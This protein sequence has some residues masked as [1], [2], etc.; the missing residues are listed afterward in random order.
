ME[1]KQ[2]R[3]LIFPQISKKHGKQKNDSRY[4]W[5]YAADLI[6]SLGGH[7]NDGMNLKSRSDASHIHHTIAE[8]IGM[9]EEKMAKKLAD[10]YLENQNEILNCDAQAMIKYITNL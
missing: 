9:D 7:D 5:T 2:S 10:Y 3:T 4:P 1:L 8:I 6:R